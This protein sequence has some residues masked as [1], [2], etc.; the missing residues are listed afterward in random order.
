MYLLFPRKN[1]VIAN[2][3]NLQ[4]YDV[5]EVIEKNKHHLCNKWEKT[6]NPDGSFYLSFMDYRKQRYWLQNSGMYDYAGVKI[7]MGEKFMIKDDMFVYQNKHGLP[8]GFTL[9]ID[10]G[11]LSDVNILGIRD[12]ESVPVMLVDSLVG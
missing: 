1:I 6:D 9:N 11:Y 12:L 10:E 8:S 4:L 3:L 5:K 2:N 7:N